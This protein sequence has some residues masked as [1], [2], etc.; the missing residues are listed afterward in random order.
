MLTIAAALVLL[1]ACGNVAGL[2]LVRAAK[3]QKE[4]A[5]RA[6]LGA[7]RWAIA[8]MLLAEGLVVGALSTIVGL[9][10]TRLALASLAPVIQQ[11]LGRSAPGG[12]EAFSIDA[13]VLL[14]AAAI[15]LLTTVMCTLIPLGASLRSPSS[16]LLSGSRTATEGRRSLRLR[17][18][19]IAAEIAVSLALLAGSTLML[20]TVV[21]LLGTDLGFEAS[22]VIN[23]SVTLRQN[24]YPD[25]PSRAAMFERISARLITV[26]GVESVG[27]TT[28][29]PLQQA[30]ALPIEIEGR[31]GQEATPATVQGVSV[32]YFAT[33][34]IPL[35]A[36]RWFTNADR[37]GAE[38][39][40]VISETLARRLSPAGAA[41][42]LRL[43]LPVDE[44]QKEQRRIVG[45]V[46][47][48][49]QVPAD[50]ELAD[51]YVPMMQAPT[52]FA[53]V[54]VRTAGAPSAWLA[55]LAAAFRDV[56]PELAVDRARPMQQD[57]DA[58]TA[59][60]RFLA[61]VLAAFAAAAA[62]L[63]LVGVY[64]VI[65]YAVRQR[66][67]EIAVRIAVGADPARITRVFLRQ[68]GGILAIGLIAGALA[69]L[70][71]GRLIESQLFGVSAHD[72]LALSLSA[73]AFAAAGLFA[74]WWPARRAAATEPAIA[75]RSE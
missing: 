8:R 38:P 2:L 53:F 24:R 42:G 66:E 30:R 45:V 48:V 16:G 10:I 51:V 43:V 18:G 19:L 55:P 25:G 68:G 70:A 31:P 54:L 21:S 75:L 22:R 62:A 5:V 12:V 29:W 49:R 56:D 32:D 52:R 58:L 23:A 44:K 39:V 17:A 71:G 41:L 72:P 9:V 73:G 35:A 4:I 27:M 67:R 57:V 15:T 59:R 47:D 7:G 26:S 1:V 14:V 63:A 33:L 34:N 65:A 37:L 20:R 11:Q 6:A 13:R 61:S 28:F 46:R 50:A 3:R 36:G 60:P 40:A 74:I 69:A 64:S